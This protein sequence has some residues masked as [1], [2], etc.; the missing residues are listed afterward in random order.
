LGI[1]GNLNNTII[2][3]AAYTEKFNIHTLN[4]G[5]YTCVCVCVCVFTLAS[6]YM[7]KV[8]RMHVIV[9]FRS[10]Q[11]QTLQYMNCSFKHI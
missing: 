3:P 2:I 4:K 9:S 5:E 6:R 11:Q 10:A 7:E 8:C 1:Q